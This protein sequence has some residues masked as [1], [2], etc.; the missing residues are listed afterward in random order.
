[1]PS[2]YIP[3]LLDRQ[4]QKYASRISEAREELA[5][6]ED[7]LDDLIGT[8]VAGIVRLHLHP[9]VALR[10]KLGPIPNV[11]PEGQEAYAEALRLVKKV[12]R[13][14]DHLHS[15]IC[16]YMERLEPPYV[17]WC[18][19]MA[20]DDIEASRGND[21]KVPLAYALR[22]LDM[23]LNRKPQ[24]MPTRREIKSFKITP[25]AL[26]GWEATFWRNRQRL[27]RFLQTAARMEED[28]VWGIFWRRAPLV[29]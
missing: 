7:S 3:S 8:A 17:V 27:V 4:H 26:E 25:E 11:P 12:K 9:S 22:L 14:T 19:G 1:M 18:Y 29:F 10:L 2:L 28:L 24:V 16:C 5:R 21:I 20:W 15:P 23:L 13:A 6:F